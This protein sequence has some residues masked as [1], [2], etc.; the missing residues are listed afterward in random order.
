M[1]LTFRKPKRYPKGIPKGSGHSRGEKPTFRK[2]TFKKPE[3]ENGVKYF[4]LTPSELKKIKG[5]HG[6]G[7]W[8]LK[9][10]GCGKEFTTEDVGQLVVSTPRNRP[11]RL[12]Y[13]KPVK[14]APKFYYHLLCFN[15]L[16]GGS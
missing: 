12:S 9:C 11:I 15:N 1:T 5:T 4:L 14:H 7:S 13:V 16:Q 3:T 2:P 10:T 6:F 8:K